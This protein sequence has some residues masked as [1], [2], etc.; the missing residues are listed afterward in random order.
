MSIFQLFHQNSKFK[1]ERPADPRDTSKWPESWTTTFYKEY[2]RY[3]VFELGQREELSMPL[4]AVIEKRHSS[5]TYLCNITDAQLS[6]LL[7]YTSGEIDQDAVY[8]RGRRASASAGARYPIETYVLLA[9]STATIPAGTYHYSVRRHALE[10]LPSEAL[11]PDVLQKLFRYPETSTAG[12]IFVYT[13]IF[14]RETNKYGERGYR[15]VLLEAG[16]IGEQ[17]YL[18]CGA[19]GVGCVGMSGYEDYALENHLGV[20]G[21]TESVVHSV[22]V[23]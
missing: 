8:G 13:G 1:R 6:S 17:L 7:W 16:G 15:N 21:I 14:Q 22:V 19:L 3:P 18:V 2:E 20:D 11:S 23:G 10:A 4:G 5:R 9:K 12:A